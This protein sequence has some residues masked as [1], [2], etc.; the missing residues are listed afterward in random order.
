[1]KDR[2]RVEGL[3]L[4]LSLFFLREEKGQKSSRPAARIPSLSLSPPSPYLI[5]I[6]LKMPPLPHD[7]GSS[8]LEINAANNAELYANAQNILSIIYDARPKNTVSLYDP[9]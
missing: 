4:A 7:S 8:R 5:K 2:Q 3:A 6:L 1:M 9:K